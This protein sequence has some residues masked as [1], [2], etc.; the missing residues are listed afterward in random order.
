MIHIVSHWSYSLLLELHV[1]GCVPRIFSKTPLFVVVCVLIVSQVASLFS[2]CCMD[3]SRLLW[4]LPL[5]VLADVPQGV[6]TVASAS[7][8]CHFNSPNI[9]VFVSPS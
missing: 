9:K 2:V 8:C 7:L 1:E 6:P 4:A 3:F 5:L